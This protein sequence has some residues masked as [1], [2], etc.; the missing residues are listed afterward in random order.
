MKKSFILFIISLSLCGC[1]SIVRIPFPMHEKY[2]DDGV[3]T[4]RVW[5][6]F[7][8][9]LPEY[10]IYTTVK[11]R[12]HVTHEMLKPIPEDWK[13]KKLH[14]A[15]MVKHWGWIPLTFIWLT[16]PFDAALDTFFLPW[17]FYIIFQNE[18]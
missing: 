15:R 10:R 6:G 2:S 1:L 13:G 18:P 11:M 14:N 7:L 8:D 17:D 4:N 16:A 12:C 9:N 3:C 5:E